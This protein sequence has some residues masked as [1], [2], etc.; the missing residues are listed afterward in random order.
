MMAF[1]ASAIAI[2]A[3]ALAGVFT[4]P[5]A[6]TPS[7]WAAKNLIVPDGPRANEKWDPELTPYVVEPLDKLGPDDPANKVVVVK[8]AQSG[9]TTLGIAFIGHAIDC[10]P[11][12]GMMVVQPTDSALTEFNRDKLGPAIE[13]TPALKKKVL[14]QKS[15]AGEGS[16]AYSKRYAGGSLTM[17]IASST[18]DLRSKTKKKIFKD[19]ASEYPAD[20]DN[21]GS[22]HS[23]IEARYESFLASG[24]WKELDVS[25]PT[26][27]GACYIS[28]E[29]ERGD[30]RRWHVVC[31]GCASKQVFKFFGGHFQ[32]NETYPYQAHYVMPCC[33][34]VVEAHEKFALV[35][36]AVRDGG[37]WIATASAP[38][39]FASYHF[40]ALSSP[41]VPWDK[42][43]QRWIEAQSD[44]AKLKAF[45]NLTLGQPYDMKG[46]APD[47]VRLMERREAD[48]KRGHI[49]PRGLMLVGAADVQLRGIYWQVVAYAPNRE[50][51]VV[52]AGLIAGDTTDAY[53]GAFAELATVYNR[54]Y[55]DA[56]GGRRRVDGFAVD[57]GFRS[58]VV[59][60]WCRTRHLAYAVKG[61]DGWSRPALG[62]PKL[63]D[64]DLGGKKISQG[65][66]LWGVG[67]WSLKGHFYEDLRREG[68]AAGREVDPAG[69]WHFATWLDDVYFRQI[70]AE[71][72]VE[73]RVRGRVTKAWEPRGKED[74]HFLDCAIYCM[75]LADHLGLTR[76]TEDEW[77]VL[78]RERAGSI[79]QGDL[80]SPRP[81]AVQIQSE[82]R[83]VPAVA[84][85]APMSPAGAARH[86]AAPETAAAPAGSGASPPASPLDHSSPN[87]GEEDARS[88]WV[89]P[90][91][92]WLQ[93]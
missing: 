75:A 13:N 49:P 68:R 19:E 81:L 16:T 70:T 31:P 24:D 66:R 4:P 93:R 42:I 50:A 48:L 91:P 35:R 64:I 74:N 47:H 15:R 63:V 87:E 79:E 86:D 41:F 46:D 67:T 11:N 85:V 84:E 36:N 26:I 12:G 5:D 72:L 18:A 52:D 92:D 60:E 58:H 22:P 29:Y 27:K 76:M 38:G 30:Q 82:P 1:K 7:A 77:R 3:G 2:V 37:G 71:A 43:A 33:G 55:H 69:Y 78:A 6:I 83:G 44:P 17:A 65:T 32:F 90:R 62:T 61:E 40:D 89:T 20:L 51:W 34:S 23:M 14:P 25:T 53:G 57:S 39:K 56:F 73:K 80:F 54:E 88:A 8:C 21:Q 45:Y 59:Y 10:D 9:F 28:E